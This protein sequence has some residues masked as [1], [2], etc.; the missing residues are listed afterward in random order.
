MVKVNLDEHAHLDSPLHQWE[1]RC[2]L[3]GLVTLIFAFSFVQDLRLLP[4]MLAVTLA[5]YAVSR[6]PLSYLLTRLRAPGFFLLLVA[7][8][9]PFLSGSTV[10][11]RIGPLAL[12]QEGCLDLA[13]VVVKF[14][15]ILTTGLVLFGSA[16][17]L[18]TVKAMRALGLP[19]T[20]A[21]MTL[22]S[23]RYLYE[24][25]DDLETMETAM[26]LRGFRARRP[27]GRALGVLASLAGSILVRSYEQ[28][29]RIYKAMILR[30]YGRAPRPRDEFQTHPCDAVALGGVL[31]V[32]VGFV[33]AEILLRGYGG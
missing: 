7:V 2:R 12:R 10:I 20:L 3:V 28:S 33:A 5:L 18:T 21:D 16:P 25:G 32:A 29:E 26:G 14:V 19:P 4:A 27:S 17:F 6:L 8:L 23:Y 13:L 11:L 24:I 1:P 15:S 31:L 30:G 22:F 9:L